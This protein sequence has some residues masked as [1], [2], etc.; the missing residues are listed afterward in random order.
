MDISL[1][2]CTYFELQSLLSKAS[3]KQ[4]LSPLSI[5]IWLKLECI[6][7]LEE[8]VNIMK[9]S[10]I[11]FLATIL[12]TLESRLNGYGIISKMQIIHLLFV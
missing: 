7:K 2:A 10:D 1:R 4:K 6:K 11:Y 5:I 9:N 3:K 8:Y 12:V